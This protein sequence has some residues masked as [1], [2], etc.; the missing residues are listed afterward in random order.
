MSLIVFLVELLFI[1][2]L[3]EFSLSDFPGGGF[4]CQQF[5]TFLRRERAGR[6]S[7]QHKRNRHHSIFINF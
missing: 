5:L 4:P 6:S 3:V 1:F 2:Y 7:L